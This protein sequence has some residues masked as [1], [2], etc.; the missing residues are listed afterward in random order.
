MT[1]QLDPYHFL[2]I[3][4]SEGGILITTD[5]YLVETSPCKCIFHRCRDIKSQKFAQGAKP[6]M[7]VPHGD[8]V[9][10]EQCV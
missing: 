8:S 6:M 3:S 1:G 9:V 10:T 2:F 4:K 5:I 7:L